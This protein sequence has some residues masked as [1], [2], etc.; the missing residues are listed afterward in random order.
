MTKRKRAL[1]TLFLVILA[2][3]VGWIVAGA[4]TPGGVK[5]LWL[6]LFKSGAEDGDGRLADQLQ[7]QADETA[8][9]L[10]D[11]EGGGS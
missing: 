1:G 3:L 2:G 6:Q 7:D 8:E 4:L 5:R 10:A 9:E 11:G